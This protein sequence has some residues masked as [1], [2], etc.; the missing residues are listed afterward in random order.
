VSEFIEHVND[1]FVEGECVNCVNVE[2]LSMY[3]KIDEERVGKLVIYEGGKFIWVVK[4]ID[5]YVDKDSSMKCK[6]ECM[7]KVYFVKCVDRS[8]EDRRSED[9]RIWEREEEKNWVTLGKWGAF[10]AYVTDRQ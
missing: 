7:S 1:R 10:E 3:K 8:E 4:R 5:I 6:K 9:E 2:I